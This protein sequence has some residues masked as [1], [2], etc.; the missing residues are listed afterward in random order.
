[1][2][3]VNMDPNAK[4]SFLERFAYGIGDYAGNLVYSAISAFLLVYYTNVVGASAASAAS[5]IAVS[6]I[7]DGISDLVMGYIVDH[8]H[9]KYGKARPWIARLCI[10]LAV[11][12]VLM[13]SVPSGFAG[14]IQIAYM[15]LT[16]NLVSTI[17]YTGINV[18]YATMNSLMTVNRYERGLLGNFRML[19]ATAGTM[20]INTVVLKM[21]GFFGGGDAYTQKGWT[22]TFVV[23]MIVFVVLNMFMFFTCKERVTEESAAEK[24]DDVPFVK[25]IAGLMKNKYWV[26]M[27]I[28][29]FAMYF[30]MSCFFGS[31]LYFTKYNMGNENQYAMVSN[32]LSAA[33]IIT[34]FVTPL[35][36]KKISKRNVFM[37]GMVIA[38][39]GFLL[40]GISTSYGIIC[41]S[42]VIKGIGFGCGAATMFGCLQEA[43]TYGEWYNGYGTAGMGNAASSFCMKIGSG[44]GTAALG[45]ILDGGGFNADLEVQTSAAL[46]SISVAFVWVPI[47]TSVICIVCMIFFNLDKYYDKVLA[48]LAQGK[49]RG[50]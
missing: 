41:L 33:Q 6:K 42:S 32:L 36:M 8:T 29:L 22:M 34:M 24:K 43:I 9:S 5:I 39:A 19:L 10:P 47:I 48:D 13:F 31:A 26:L 27:V 18:P 17:F 1:M 44:I 40:A 23:L 38:T 46:N 4:L 16:Y 21:T 30:M 3:A 45:W 37:I 20:T 14:K 2:K 49:H 15:F 50:E 7:L 35:L 25:G 11:C 28:A 12:T